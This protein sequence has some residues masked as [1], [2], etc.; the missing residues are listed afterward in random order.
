MCDALIGNIQEKTM[1]QHKATNTEVVLYSY[2][3]GFLYLFV[4]LLLTGDI[5]AGASF[6][7][8]VRIFNFEKLHL[9]KLN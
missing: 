5:F 9:K 1:K 3:I 4:V 7:N 6:C 2:S 8:K